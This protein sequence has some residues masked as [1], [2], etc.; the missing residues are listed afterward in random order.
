MY[1]L[2]YTIVLVQYIMSVQS[3]EFKFEGTDQDDG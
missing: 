3:L 2:Y 1:I